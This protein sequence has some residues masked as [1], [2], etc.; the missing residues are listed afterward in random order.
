MVKRMRFCLYLE[1]KV[2]VWVEL[3]VKIYYKSIVA[4]VCEWNDNLK[5]FYIDLGLCDVEGDG[6]G[7]CK[8]VNFNRVF[9]SVLFNKYLWICCN[10]YM[11]VCI[12]ICEYDVYVICTRIEGFVLE[13]WVFEVY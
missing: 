4:F 11:V 2:D 9:W 12:Y 13:K 10:Q 8:Y 7:L 3:H 6:L 1:F 5:S